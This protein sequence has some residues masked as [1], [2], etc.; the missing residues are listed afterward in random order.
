MTA[1]DRARTRLMGLWNTVQRS[2]HSIGSRVP[3][4]VQRFLPYQSSLTPTEQ[5]AIAQ[6]AN[7][8][9]SR[10]Y[11]FPYTVRGVAGTFHTSVN[12]LLLIDPSFSTAE[13]AIRAKL[14]QWVRDGILS[15]NP[16]APG[17]IVP[18]PAARNLVTWTN[19]PMPSGI[20]GAPLDTRLMTAQ[21]ADFAP[22][23]GL[24]NTF[25]GDTGPSTAIGITA[26]SGDLL[27]SFPVPNRWRKLYPGPKLFDST[28]LSDSRFV[29]ELSDLTTQLALLSQGGNADPAWHPAFMFFNTGPQFPSWQYNEP[30]GVYGTVFHEIDERWRGYLAHRW[31]EPKHGAARNNTGINILGNRSDVWNTSLRARTR[32]FTAHR[33]ENTYNAVHKWATLTVADA[34]ADFC[35]W[36]NLASFMV[37]LGASAH[38]HA[39]LECHN[40]VAGKAMRE[41]GLGVGSQLDRSV[42]RER[43]ARVA[44]A[45]SSR[46]DQLNE[47]IAGLELANSQEHADAVDLSMSILRGGAVASAQLFAANPIVGG[48][49]AVVTVVGAVVAWLAAG[50]AGARKTPELCYVRDGAAKVR[51]KDEGDDPNGD[52]FGGNMYPWTRDEAIRGTP[53]IRVADA[54]GRVM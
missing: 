48:I 13:R 10:D 34:V 50:G 47:Y 33:E 32:C 36:A 37:D 38:A 6:W 3:P 51:D 20:W 39:A 43:D 21:W 23:G 8:I 44:R 9:P 4:S 31:A 54:S 19:D 27:P 14:D 42:G 35:R 17:T 28:F 15:W 22:Y 2:A 5:V 29:T 26:A 1:L 25:N 41:L 18:P 49:A 24:R 45:Q 40:S 11:E 16:P 12:K 7:A 46:V 52:V 53:I 30:A